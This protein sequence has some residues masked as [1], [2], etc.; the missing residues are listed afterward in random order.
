MRTPSPRSLTKLT[1][2]QF[3][4][5]GDSTSKNRNFKAA[6]SD[7]KQILSVYRKMLEALVPQPVH[8]TSELHRLLRKRVPAFTG[9]RITG[10][11][12]DKASGMA[13]NPALNSTR[14]V[15]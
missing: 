1:P 9:A 5:S 14:G 2:L 10:S 3:H 15:L 7:A 13:L 12:V 6:V 8:L 4:G 11:C